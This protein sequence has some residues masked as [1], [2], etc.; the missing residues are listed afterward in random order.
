MPTTTTTLLRRRRLF[1]LCS[2][3]RRLFCRYRRR[4]SSSS[5]RQRPRNGRRVIT[6]AIVDVVDVVVQEGRNFSLMGMI[7]TRNVMHNAYNAA[8]REFLI[9]PHRKRDDAQAEPIFIYRTLS[10][11]SVVSTSSCLGFSRTYRNRGL[12]V[13]VRS[14][15][16]VFVFV[17]VDVDVEPV[18]TMSS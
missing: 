6:T 9:N 8:V 11:R 18:S 14:S 15:S 3:R 4:P 2:R 17:D 13:A 10:S 12:V 16:S 7:R 1:Y 5:S